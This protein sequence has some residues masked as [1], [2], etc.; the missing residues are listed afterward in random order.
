MK[1]RCTSLENVIGGC[2]LRYLIESRGAISPSSEA[3][4]RG[5][6]THTLLEYAVKGETDQ[7]KHMLS[8]LSTDKY[9]TFYIACLNHFTTWLNE[10]DVQV[11]VAE[12]KYFIEHTLKDNTRV[13]L[14]G[15]PDLIAKI[16]IDNVYY[17]TIVDYKTSMSPKE[18][19]LYKY[20]IIWYA[21]MAQTIGEIPIQKVAILNFSGGSKTVK[22]S[23]IYRDLQ[24]AD[25]DWLMQIIE[26]TNALE[27][28]GYF[29]KNYN[30]G[31]SWCDFKDICKQLPETVNINTHEDLLNQLIAKHNTDLQTPGLINL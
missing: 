9:Y 24:Q 18:S 12:K 8:Q 14:T 25:L 16:K 2:P 20:Q 6:N 27:K 5:T 7:L 22:K 23:F 19:D 30:G 28:R 11:L 21:Y 29:Q 3:A 10:Y 1:F 13:T 4:T 17:N 26:Y 31:C 15:K